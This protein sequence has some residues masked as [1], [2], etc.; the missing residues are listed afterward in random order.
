VRARRGG[1]ITDE[2]AVF[3]GGW[4]LA[5]RA[6]MLGLVDRLGDLDGVARAIAGEKARTEIF[7]PRRRGLLG[8]LPRVLAEAVFDVMEER[9]RPRL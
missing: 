7:K 4:M 6:L 8:R 5:E 1:K 9:A 3:D 2:A